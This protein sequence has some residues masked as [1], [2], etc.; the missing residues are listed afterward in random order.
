MSGSVRK[1]IDIDK[2]DLILLSRIAI[3]DNVSLKKTIETVIAKFCS[4]P[5]WHIEKLLKN[6]EV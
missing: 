4:L 2:K 1:S 5:D 3:S 6:K